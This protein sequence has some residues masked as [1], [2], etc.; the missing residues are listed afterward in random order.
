MAIVNSEV[1]HIASLDFDLQQAYAQFEELERRIREEGKTLADLAKANWKIGNVFEDVSSGAKQA[2]SQIDAVYK[3]FGTSRKKAIEQMRAE[4]NPYALLVDYLKNTNGKLKIQWDEQFR[5][6]DENIK[7]SLSSY[8]K[9]GG[10]YGIDSISGELKSMFP[11][12]FEGAD[13]E[14]D[15]MERLYSAVNKYREQLADIVSG[16][17]QAADAAKEYA[18]KMQILVDAYED[19]D[20]LSDVKIGKSLY[21]YE[22]L[23]AMSEAVSERSNTEAKIT[24]QLD[25]QGKM[26]AAN[27]TYTDKFNNTMQEQWK[28]VEKVNAETG[29]AEVGFKKMGETI[30]YS[31]QN[32]QK[33]YDAFNKAASVIE[34]DLGKSE[35]IFASKGGYEEQL[36]YIQSIKREIDEIRES[37]AAYS[38]DGQAQLAVLKERADALAKEAEWLKHSSDEEQKIARAR[39]Q[40]LSLVQ[41]TASVQKTIRDLE[42]FPELQ[43]R[44]QLLRQESD[45]LAFTLQ[46]KTKIT[47]EEE[48][49]LE[50]IRSRLKVLQTEVALI[51]KSDYT[52]QRE[53]EEKAVSAREKS[54]SILKN[55]S[56]TQ[57]TIRSLEN[58][59]ELEERAA[60]VREEAEEL[61]EILV[62]KTRITN[63]DEEQLNLLEQRARQ[64]QN[65]AAIL[66]NDQ[67][68]ASENILSSTLQKFSAYE[69]WQLAKEVA[70]EFIITLNDVETAMVDIDRV[71]GLTKQQSDDLR[72][73]LFDVAQTYGQQ[74]ESA[75][76]ITLR[77]AQAGYSA[78]ESLKL[79]EAALLAMNTAELDAENSTDSLV[80]ILKQ[81]GLEADSLI[82][83]IDK[84]NYTADTNAVTTQDLVDGLLRSSSAARNANIDFDNTVGLLTVMA[85]TSGRT[86]KEVGTAL[87]SLI[88]YTQRASS[89]NVFENLGVKVYADETRTSLVSIMDI[90][91]Q[92]AALIQKGGDEVI[93]TLAEQTDL[94]SLQSEE[95]AGA[96]GVTEEYNQL[97]EAQNRI[98]QEGLTDL[99]R[100][101]VYEQAGVYRRNYMISLLSEFGEVSKI[102]A[103]ME[104]A[105][106]H[107]MQ[108]NARYMD[109]L[110][111]KYTQLIDS[112][113]E[114]AVEAGDSGF[115][116]IAKGALDAAN[117]LLK[118]TQ[119]VG[120]L[121]TALLAVAAAL[122]VIKREQIAS[123][124]VTIKTSI[125]GATSSVKEWIKQLIA[126][127]G[128][129]GKI[130]FSLSGLSTAMSGAFGGVVLGGTILAIGALNK[131]IEKSIQSERNLNQE[132]V[133][134]SSQL[135]EQVQKLQEQVLLYEQLY[136]KGL[137]EKEISDQVLSIQNEINN[138]LGKKAEN[139]DLV[140]GK[141]DKQLA[142]LRQMTEEQRQQ[143]IIEA[144]GAKKLAESEYL[145][146]FRNDI[147]DIT[148]L[149]YVNPLMRGPFLD[150]LETYG[151]YAENASEAL[152][153]VR[154]KREEM[155]NQEKIDPK[156]YEIVS[157]VISYLETVVENY[158]TTQRN[159]AILN[160][161]T[162][163]TTDESTDAL[164]RYAEMLNSSTDVL[165]Y[166]VE[167]IDDVNAHM[168]TLRSNL[169]SLESAM[170]TVANGG[171]LTAD[172]MID[173][174]AKFPELA[175]AISF[176]NGEWY[177]NADAMEQVRQAQYQKLMLDQALI[178][179]QELETQ[180]INDQR[181]SLEN[182]SRNLAEAT[183]ATAKQAVMTE[184]LAAAS[185]IAASGGK[186]MSDAYKSAVATMQL[187]QSLANTPIVPSGTS[188]RGG[189]SGV[190]SA[191]QEQSKAQQQAIQDHIDALRDESQAVQKEYQNQIKAIQELQ[192]AEQEAYQEKI[193]QLQKE[194][195]AVKESYDA[196]IE[197]LKDA[198]DEAE[199]LYDQRKEMLEEQ[200]DAEIDK[201]N[202][203]IDA[204]K[205]AA[206]AEIDALRK[207]QEQNTRQDA[208]EE[209]EKKRNELLAERE[210]M[211]KRTNREAVE[212][213]AEID[214][215]LEELDYEWAKKQRDWELE[216]QIEAIEDRR[217]TEIDALEDQKEAQEEFFNS[218]LEQL[219]KEEEERKRNYE[220]ELERLEDMRDKETQAIDDRIESLQKEKE[221]NDKIHQAR[222]DNLNKEL[223]AIKESYDAR[224]EASN[225][226][227]EAVKKNYEAMVQA[228]RN[229]A[230]QIGGISIGGGSSESEREARY[231]A[232][233]PRPPQ[234][235]RG[236]GEA[237]SSFNARIRAWKQ[238]LVEWRKRY[239]AAKSSGFAGWAKGTDS[240]PESGL[241]RFD[242]LGEELIV[243]NQAGKLGWFE[244]GDG[245]VPA[246]LTKN[247]M[248]WGKISPQRL[249]VDPAI[250]SGISRMAAI[251][252]G[253]MG[254]YVDN[255][256]RVEVNFN[257]PIQSVGTQEIGDTADAELMAKNVANIMYR[258]IQDMVM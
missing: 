6:I 38:K 208:E 258:K 216:D 80:G 82:T 190:S 7:K 230:S 156:E 244:K 103:K 166:V 78:Q 89:L 39:S 91:G 233:N 8:I 19:A 119:A 240:V 45:A 22:D 198:N 30:N 209:Y 165:D 68:N 61:R 40:S 234:P 148:G 205:E 151:A 3:S 98:N 219:E 123:S 182:L 105:E 27:L 220:N 197:A 130:Q 114:L 254:S 257:A 203:Q 194:K 224:I 96:F 118:V 121:D 44:A 129:I 110:Q 226:E 16:N 43:Q 144:A 131:E 92:L 172:T 132:S 134:T 252:R 94:T 212:R 196:Q 138:I 204:I 163:E 41:Q 146:G 237:N 249:I 256:R 86:G 176:Q 51:S 191:A 9:W 31:A 67:S 95:I 184:Y 255:S 170:Q 217:D 192:K 251:E 122:A 202:E 189:S 20:D 245:V 74:F 238:S 56:S 101:Q 25:G 115:M 159:H 81:W 133:E 71:L 235:V 201:I 215:E 223:E 248:E 60:A 127:Q 150:D 242:E 155:V 5:Y 241:Y 178:I 147:K 26:I 229:A 64:L 164:A 124:L 77:F 109:T 228:A 106:G 102:A 169:N 28:W 99:E 69:L 34:T 108:E 149:A 24:T 53:E 23:K 11:S 142:K 213:I 158:N 36:E 72:D 62:Q 207:T 117:A 46:S 162:V 171:E 88:S 90:W 4:G 173:L 75:S 236:N 15:V 128:A 10:S 1:Q 100:K 153:M 141:Y 218:K 250:T 55:I 83:I 160:G 231:L 76:E 47:A 85:E 87:N 206:Q 126:V 239:N 247:L 12:I 35:S 42:D 174:L 58:A 97:L 186:N 52:T 29:E 177:L 137:S 180:N 214:K 93:N 225:R 243:R 221:A 32:A 63:E 140:N 21:S 111:A 107:S 188:Y 33:L 125:I 199:E 73:S 246:N 49:Q 161:K 135:T 181:L 157:E 222:I 211:E 152:E 200:R 18:E 183:D 175:S 17:Q 14:L 113:K 104:E 66:R 167:N 37:G 79:T 193:E 50:N 253:A 195:E 227:L 65:E 187:L 59:D 210:Q 136:D 13:A 185:E 120:G 168:E 116:D 2:E 84:L 70:T 54:L 139:L 154:K 143:A 57:K 112:L 179:N 48:Q 232:A 145:E